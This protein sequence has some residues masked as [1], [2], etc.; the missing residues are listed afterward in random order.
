MV[1]SGYTP[2]AIHTYLKFLYT[3]MLPINVELAIGKWSE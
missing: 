1:I 3:D 2:A